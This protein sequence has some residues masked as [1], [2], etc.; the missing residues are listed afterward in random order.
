MTRH[1]AFTGGG[2]MSWGRVAALVLLAV[3]SA[4]WLQR[5]NAAF[6]EWLRRLTDLPTNIALVGTSGFERE[7][8][9]PTKR[10]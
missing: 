9:D 5:N 3:G 2:F 10:P 6:G 1:E 7:G 8:R 4:L